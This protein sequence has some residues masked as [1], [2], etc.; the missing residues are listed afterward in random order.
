MCMSNHS[1]LYRDQFPVPLLESMVPFLPVYN[2]CKH[3]GMRKGYTE[4]LRRV[5]LDLG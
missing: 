5:V 4:T 3:I 1:L 2:K